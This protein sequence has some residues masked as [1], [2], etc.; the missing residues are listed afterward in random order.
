[1]LKFI[2]YPKCTTCQKAKKWLDNNGIE[3]E[4]RDIKTDNPTLDELTLWYELRGRRGELLGNTQLFFCLDMQK[5]TFN[6]R[7]DEFRYNKLC[8]RQ[9]SRFHR[10]CGGKSCLEQT[11]NCS[12]EH[13]DLSTTQQFQI[14][15]KNNAATSE[16]PN[17]LIFSHE[18]PCGEWMHFS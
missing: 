13:R 2:C 11:I 17:S 3:Y 4:L 12:H 1:M 15:P 10:V 14:L 18:L 6:R 7:T 9:T 8:K 16:M 5:P